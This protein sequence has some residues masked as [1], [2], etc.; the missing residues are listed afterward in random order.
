MS[1]ILKRR[2]MEMIKI[3]FFATVCL[4]LSGCSTYFQIGKNKG[5]CEEHGC[6]FSDAGFCLGPY[7]MYQKKDSI[8]EQAYKDIQCNNCKLKTKT[9]V[10]YENE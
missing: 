9:K 10:V 7:E 4:L 2:K 5:Y 1:N 6:D 3:I 8:K